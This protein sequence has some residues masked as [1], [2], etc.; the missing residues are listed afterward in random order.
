MGRR[1]LK[2]N[3][4]FIMYLISDSWHEK[5]P[6]NARKT[7]S[8]LQYSSLRNLFKTRFQFTSRRFYVRGGRL[9]FKNSNPLP[10][11]SWRASYCQQRYPSL[12]VT[13]LLSI[14]NNSAQTRYQHLF[15]LHYITYQL[16]SWCQRH[17]N[18]TRLLL[19]QKSLD[20]QKNKSKS[21]LDAN[22]Q[23]TD[24]HCQKKRNYF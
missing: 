11:V 21:Q 1:H 2:P 24:S 10:Q 23:N 13:A 7:T 12:E 22:K 8:N 4:N 20:Y 17:L 15:H 16:M 14:E 9:V 19:T 5:K 18:Q 3:N 6:F